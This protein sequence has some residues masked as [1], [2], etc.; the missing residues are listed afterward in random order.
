[1]MSQTQRSGPNVDAAATALGES[2]S[3]S[4]GADASTSQPKLSE[5]FAFLPD[6]VVQ[7]YGRKPMLS[8]THITT[9]RQC[10]RLY[11][12]RHIERLPEPPTEPLVAGILVHEALEQLYKYVP[13]ADRT[14]PKLQELFRDAWRKV[15]LTRYRELFFPESAEG[16]AEGGGRRRRRRDAVG[17]RRGARARAW[18]QAALG[19]M[20]NYFTLEDPTEVT[21]E[22]VEQ[23]VGA[24]LGGGLEV[25]G[26]IDRLEV[27]DSDGG[28]AIV[29]YK[30]GNAPSQK[31]S[32]AA[33][34]KIRRDAFFQLYVYAL[35]LREGAN[36]GAGSARRCASCGCSTSATP[37]PSPSPSTPRASTRPPPRCATSGTASSPPSKRRPSSRS[38]ARSASSARTAT[39][40][41][42]TA[43]RTLYTPGPYRRVTFDK[44]YSVS[45]RQA[46]GRTSVTTICVTDPSRSSSSSSQVSAAPIGATTSG[47]SARAPARRRPLKRAV[48]TPPPR[49]AA[50]AIVVLHSCS[51]STTAALGAVLDQQVAHRARAVEGGAA[52][53]RARRLERGLSRSRPHGLASPDLPR[54]APWPAPSPTCPTPSARVGDAPA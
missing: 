16:G 48:A 6:G 33:N 36:D 7:V 37:P 39:A 41:R 12:L 42:R 54:E 32:A 34:A 1:M 47:A 2:S 23:W 46:S 10:P 14:L 45:E 24:S 40:A 51:A 26:K 52:A 43:V 27:V 9:F 8:P 3:S 20:A 18:G 38:P 17:G 50:A 13:A 25:R 31:Y 44:A 19:K 53:R 30:T 11:E 49:A 15:R 29:D 28:L 21:P 35:L 4:D 5:R 22:S